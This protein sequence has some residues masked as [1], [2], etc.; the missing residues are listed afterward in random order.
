MNFES[1]ELL[2][3]RVKETTERLA[4]LGQ[5]NAELAARVSELEQELAAAQASAGG[6]WTKERD[7]LRRRI[8]KLAARLAQALES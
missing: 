2:E 3:Q 5:R 4:E 1:L 8:E 7:Q 6:S